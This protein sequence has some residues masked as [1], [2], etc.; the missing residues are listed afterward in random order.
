VDDDE[1]LSEVEENDAPSSDEGENEDEIFYNPDAV[2][3]DVAN[4]DFDTVHWKVNEMPVQP[5]M[6]FLGKSGPTHCLNPATAV[7]LDYFL[8]FIPVFFWNKWADYT[9][10]KAEMTTSGSEQ[11]HRR[12]GATCAAEI[13][14][15]VAAIM[16][17]C[18][19]RNMNLFD[20]YHE[21]VN[22]SKIQQWFPSWTRLEQLKRFIKLSDPDAEHGQKH[23]KLHKVREIWDEFISRCK[24]N[25]WPSMEVALDEAIKKFKGRCSFKQYIKNK[26]TK[27]GLK[28]FCVCCSATGYL[29]NASVYLG[30]T[31][32]DADTPTRDVSNTIKAVL[33][34]LSPLSFKNHIVIMDNFYTSVAL[35]MGLLT[36]G[37][38]ACGTI[39]A[40]RKGLCPEVAIKKSEESKLKKDP[41][42]TRWASWG[43]LC[44]I[45][46]FAKR[47]VHI[48]TN[49]YLPVGNGPD[50]T[51]K[52]WFTEKGEKVQKEIKKPPAI[53]YYNMYMGAVDLFDQYRSYIGLDF[54]SNK[55]WHPLMWFIFETALVN[56]WILYKT[57]CEAAKVPLKYNHFQ[58]RRSI[59]LALAKE[60]EM[61]GCRP[62]AFPVTT[63]TKKWK[64]SV[65]R[66][67]FHLRKGAKLNFQGETD[68]LEKHLS[69]MQKIPLREGSKK[70][71]RQ[72]KCIVCNK[73]LTTFWCKLCEVPLCRDGC[74]CVY[75]QKNNV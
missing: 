29:W 52:H 74:F 70:S 65:K 58:F 47:A 30:R 72:L 62:C 50:A 16:W 8:L 28:V 68:T 51:V 4:F 63:P 18:L 64:Q 19:W 73:R 34:L 2:A 35:F 39:R 71:S 43:A 45:A 12:W 9:N 55:Y 57:T 54:R 42:Y 48:L 27:W 21:K 36:M 49:C 41:G 23:D 59:A 14:A 20:F 44:Y 66:A 24:A 60:W 22:P 38:R 11:K 40:N 15:F 1:L 6:D 25:Y 31:Q 37:I 69:Q 10:R 56:S 26:P 75:H 3:V 13:K 46:W 61:M 33:T 32:E 53:T 17:W 67:R 7:P 5:H